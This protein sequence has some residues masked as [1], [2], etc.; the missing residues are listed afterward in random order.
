[1]SAPANVALEVRPILFTESE[2]SY[3]KMGDWSAHANGIR[4]TLRISSIDE[5]GRVSGTLSDEPITGWWSERARPLTFLRE[6]RQTD[7]G[8]MILRLG[9]RTSS[10]AQTRCLAAEWA[11]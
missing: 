4:G 3:L 9:A 10:Q 11:L 7:P 8:R 6:D 1:V 2:V 5:L